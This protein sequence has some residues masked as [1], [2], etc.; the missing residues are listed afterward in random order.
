MELSTAL[1]ENNNCLTTT[2]L[3][4]VRDNGLSNKPVVHEP[5]LYH[6]VTGQMNQRSHCIIV[7]L[8]IF[9]VPE[10]NHFQTRGRH[11]SCGAQK[12]QVVVDF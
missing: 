2:T 11:I 9:N 6:A 5:R 3:E 1:P 8:T 4:E 12:N 10:Q 7:I